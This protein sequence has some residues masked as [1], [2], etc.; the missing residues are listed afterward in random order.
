MGD[1]SIG[2]LGAWLMIIS[3]KFKQKIERLKKGYII[4]IYFL[5]FLIFFFRDEVLLAN[6]QIRIFE[7][8][9][10]ASVFILI[11]L[12]QCYANNSFFKLSNYKKI[13]RLGEI[14]YGLYCFHFIC[15]LTIT[16]LTQILSL[17]TK[18]WQVIFLETTLAFLL[19]VLISTMS[20]KYFE[21][22]F[23]KLKNK[24][25]FITK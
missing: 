21:K 10:I 9:I 11:I 19:T 4:I 8:I 6:Y 3:E 2:A 16:T 12:E 7:R 24:F 15:I 23:L 1:M 25:S 13:T 18:L 14:T 5:F 17:N 20:Y 22:P